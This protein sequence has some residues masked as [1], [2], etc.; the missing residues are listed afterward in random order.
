MAYS[1]SAIEAARFAIENKLTP[2]EAWERAVAKEFPNSINNQLKGCPKNTFLGLCEEGYIKG[3]EPG[4]YTSSVLNK[5]Y[6][7]I[8]VRI[9]LL[10]KDRTFSNIDLWKEVLIHLDGNLKKQH[11]SQMN[12]VLALW[13]E[14]LLNIE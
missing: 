12:V 6:G 2:L 13:N 4:T 14:G 7:I 8:A 11:N 1:S 3:V 5:Q 10:D 9:L